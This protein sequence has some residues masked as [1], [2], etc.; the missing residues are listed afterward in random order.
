[1][2]INVE[3]NYVIWQETLLHVNILYFKIAIID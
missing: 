2:E 3:T 1:M